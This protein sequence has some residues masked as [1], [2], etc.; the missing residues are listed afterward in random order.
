MFARK[1]REDKK[2]EA[3]SATRFA[4]FLFTVLR[5]WMDYGFTARK[6]VVTIRDSIQGLP[7]IS[8]HPN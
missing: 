7:F 6:K 5:R 4:R 1:K 2:E 8:L 3:A